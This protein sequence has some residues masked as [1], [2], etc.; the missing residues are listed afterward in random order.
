MDEFGSLLCFLVCHVPHHDLSR[1]RDQYDLII[2]HA[3]TQLALLALLNIAHWK[4]ILLLCSKS[5][6]KKRKALFLNESVEES[7]GQYF[8]LW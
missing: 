5:Q 6:H 1:K 2:L 8:T 3:T 4:S 7:I